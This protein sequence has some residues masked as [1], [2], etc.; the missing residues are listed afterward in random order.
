M[1]YTIDDAWKVFDRQGGTLRTHQALEAGIHPRVLY[2]LRDA[3]DLLE[4]SRGV[5]RLAWLDRLTDPNL[6]RVATRVP[7]GVFCLHTALYFHKLVNHS[8]REV[9]LAIARSMRAPKIEQLPLRVY[10]VQP[11]ALLTGV[12]THEIDGIE[13]NFFEV[14][15]TLVDCF[16]YR[17]KIGMGVAIESLRRYQRRRVNDFDK[18]LFYAGLSRIERLMRPYLEALL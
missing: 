2:Q 12:E 18:V 4:I 3:G 8:P 9:H 11:D 1:A 17:N 10:R 14:E 6:A 7:Q 5:Y 15:K 16:K 13:M